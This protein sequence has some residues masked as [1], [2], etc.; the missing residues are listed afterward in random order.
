MGT[1][2][3][4]HREALELGAW[5]YRAGRERPGFCSRW[6]RITLPA[7]AGQTTAFSCD[8]EAGSLQDSLKAERTE[9]DAP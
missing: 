4:L 5:R 3:P 7:D 9:D 1:F 2:R 8:R 6:L